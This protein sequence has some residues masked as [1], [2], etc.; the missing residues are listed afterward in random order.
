MPGRF[1][2][3]ERGSWAQRLLMVLLLRCGLRCKFC[4][5]VLSADGI[6]GVRIV[7]SCL[8]LYR[9]CV[10]PVVAT[11]QS[12]WPLATI[13]KN[14]PKR[15]GAPVSAC[16]DETRKNT[17]RAKEDTDIL[18]SG[19]FERCLANGS[20]VAFGWFVV[21]FCVPSKTNHSFL[22]RALSLGP[23]GQ[24]DPQHDRNPIDD[25]RMPRAMLARIGATG[26]RCNCS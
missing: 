14:R 22:S 10:L 7:L 3:F 13:S 16:S 12:V 18:I 25:R 11:I 15:T 1:F 4:F 9:A 23:R 2:C 5:V 19:V 6:D 26:S 8:V 17:K 20:F 21:W 24:L